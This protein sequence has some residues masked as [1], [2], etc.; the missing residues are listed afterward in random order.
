MDMKTHTTEL[1]LSVEDF[2][3]IF[4]VTVADIPQKCKDVISSTDFRY[5]F[6][7][8]WERDNVL[9]RVVKTL[10][11]DTLKKSGPHRKEDWEKGWSEN[12]SNFVTHGHDIEELI[13]KFV[14]KKEMVRFRGDYIM[15]ADPDFETN[16]V[17]IIRYYLF[18]K[19]FAETAKVFEF[20]CGTGLNLIAVSELF[21]QK[22]LYG[23]DW[24]EASC[25]ILNELSKK[26]HLNLTG[27]LFDMFSPDYEVEVDNNSA[28]FTIGAM[29][30]LGNNF[31]PFAEFLLRKNPSLVINIEVN[32]ES[33]DKDSLFEYVAAAYIEKRNYLRGFY[34]FLQEQ[35]MQGRVTIMETRKT[36]G[37]LFHDG[38]SY[39]VWKPRNSV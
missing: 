29:E 7:S 38:Y 3:T 19:Y 4:G 36:F 33:H 10:L 32:Y 17:K 30:Q 35:E 20:G 6:L 25:Q 39:T 5:Q 27:V 22:K 31:M 15:P 13:P 37:S 26:C 18:S 16:F 2:A 23:L 8:G 34:E 1:H 14:R 24:S 12:F 9:L 21:P 28:V 11:S